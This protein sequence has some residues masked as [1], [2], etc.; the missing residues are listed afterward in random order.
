MEEWNEIIEES[1]ISCILS[2]I[3]WYHIVCQLKGHWSVISS[4]LVSNI[5]SSAVPY[6]MS[7]EGPFEWRRPGWSYTSSC[8]PSQM[9]HV[10][11][12]WDRHHWF[13]PWQRK[14]PPRYETQPATGVEWGKNKLWMQ[15][16]YLPNK[17][18]TNKQTN[19][20]TNKLLV[21]FT[22]QSLT[23]GGISHFRRWGLG[24]VN[25]ISPWQ[26]PSG[27]YFM[28]CSKLQQYSSK[29][30]TI[31]ASALWVVRREVGE[32]WVHVWPLEKLCSLVTGNCGGTPP[33][34][35]PLPETHQL[36]SAFTPI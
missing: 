10:S 14:G 22:V 13:A 16:F 33:P 12:K 18:T 31:G 27:R 9:R 28:R 4:I 5:W 25:L 3:L 1:V 36:C 11:D 7:A 6:S 34:P 29:W 17:Q 15:Y 24:G 21:I 30:P 20:Q 32:G 19:K 8:L 23:G 35:P 2:V 26:W